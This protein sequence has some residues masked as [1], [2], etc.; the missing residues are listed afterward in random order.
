MLTPLDQREE[1]ILLKLRELPENKMA[2]VLDFVDFLITRIV[3]RREKEGEE[4]SY[5][6]ATLRKK[7]QDRGGLA[8]GKTQDK[9]LE[10]LRR[11]RESVWK[12]DYENHFRHQ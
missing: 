7:I 6:L 8:L 4:Y 3:L 11:T 2:E 1:K 9:R 10:K 5:Y 12:E